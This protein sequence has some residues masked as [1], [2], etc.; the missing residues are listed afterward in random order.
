M[1][2]TSYHAVGPLSGHNHVYD[3]K[4]MS[5]NGSTLDDASVADNDN[6]NNDEKDGD[7]VNCITTN[8]KSTDRY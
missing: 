2:A 4:S 3:R 7:I 8:D 6:D 5:S 1:L